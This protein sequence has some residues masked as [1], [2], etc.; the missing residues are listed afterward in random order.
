MTT[1]RWMPAWAFMVA[2]T[3][4]SFMAV[5][6]RSLRDDYFERRSPSSL[7][8]RWVWRAPA[9]QLDRLYLRKDTLAAAAIPAEESEASSAPPLQFILN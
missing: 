1:M 5:E 2:A 4:A 8:A 3:V 7:P 9:H 6:G